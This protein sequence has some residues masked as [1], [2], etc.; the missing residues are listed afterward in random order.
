MPLHRRIQAL[1]RLVVR[2][3]LHGFFDARGPDLAAGL[4]YSSLLTIVPLTA[5]ITVLTT[6]LFG[7][8]GTGVYRLIRVLVPGASSS[9]V[10]DIQQT[11]ATART[12]SGWGAFFF[13]GAALRLF[14]VF[15]GS[16]NAL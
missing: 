13:L 1:I 12:V 9:I 7:D 2:R 15:E 4:A 11:A 3:T 16:A 5:A 10:H 6:T 14:F 8:P